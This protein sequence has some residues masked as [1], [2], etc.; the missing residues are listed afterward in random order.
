MWKNSYGPAGSVNTRGLPSTFRLC[1]FTK[2][3][4]LRDLF[5]TLN[6]FYKSM[7][8]KVN[9]CLLLSGITSVGFTAK[10]TLKSILVTSEIEVT[11]SG[12]FRILSDV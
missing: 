5:L 2:K 10:I 4:I 8:T 9:S 7:H 6:N 12:V 11:N 1:K 3:Y